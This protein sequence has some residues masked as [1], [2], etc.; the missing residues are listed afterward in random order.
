MDQ[1]LCKTHS[2]YFISIQ[3]ITEKLMNTN[4]FIDL[5]TTQ[6]NTVY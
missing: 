5:L 3:G 6:Y 4:D 1:L 2:S